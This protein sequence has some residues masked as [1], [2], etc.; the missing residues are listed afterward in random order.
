MQ[1][2]CSLMWGTTL[3]SPPPT[4]QSIAILVV[5]LHYQQNIFFS[6]FLHAV[7]IATCIILLQVDINITNKYYRSTLMKTSWL[8]LKNSC[9]LWNSTL[10][11]V[12][13]YNYNQ[14]TVPEIT[15]ILQDLTN[16]MRNLHNLDLCQS[17]SLSTSTQEPN[18]QQISWEHIW[19]YMKLKIYNTSHVYKQS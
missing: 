2:T 16:S 6:I 3:W 14:C 5:L 17:S 8:V 9:N 19:N 1:L 7:Y 18:W 15:T 11:V 4:P 12:E 13:D 10:V